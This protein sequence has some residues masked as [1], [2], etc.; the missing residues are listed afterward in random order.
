M[1]SRTLAK[2][3]HEDPTIEELLAWEEQYRGFEASE[4]SK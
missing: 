4:E 3:K 2:Q 1:N